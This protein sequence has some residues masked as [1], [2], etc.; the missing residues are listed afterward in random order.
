[1]CTVWWRSW[2]WLKTFT[3]K[4]HFAWR[5]SGR[6]TSASKH[7]MTSHDRR[8]C[9]LSAT[10]SSWKGVCHAVAAGWALLRT[11]PDD[12]IKPVREG[13]I[14]MAKAETV[15]E[16]KWLR[17]KGIQKSHVNV[18]K[19][20]VVIAVPIVGIVDLLRLIQMAKTFHKTYKIN[21]RQ[22]LRPPRTSFPRIY[23]TCGRN[24]AFCVY[25]GRIG[26]LSTVIAA[27][28]WVPYPSWP[29]ISIVLNL[30][31]VLAFGGSAPRKL[32]FYV[33]LRF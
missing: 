7:V 17:Q 24:P 10:L 29:C 13:Y 14:R 33:A 4:R 30:E 23:V 9:P 21:I 18:N 26:Q 32:A 31:T 28:H 27:A 12:H 1:M 22:N 2:R 3:W 19:L 6:A 16:H 15:L 20:L 11:S 25:I 8:Y 5:W